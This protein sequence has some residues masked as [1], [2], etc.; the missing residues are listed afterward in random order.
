MISLYY[1]FNKVTNIYFFKRIVWQNIYIVYTILFK[2]IFWIE[3]KDSMSNLIWQRLKNCRYLYCIS[4]LG[5]LIPFRIF[6]NIQNKILIIISLI[7][8]GELCFESIYPGDTLIPAIQINASSG[9]QRKLSNYEFT[10]W[11][12]DVADLAPWILVSFW[13]TSR[14]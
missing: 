2:Y 12:Y 1:S 5:Q 13:N 6:Q 3:I 11:V 9:F 7:E 14:P 8:N 4:L 10:G